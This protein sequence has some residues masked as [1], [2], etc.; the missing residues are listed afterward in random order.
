[1]AAAPEM[2]TRRSIGAGLVGLALAGAVLG[3]RSTNDA[4]LAS[5][6]GWD[7]SRAEVVTWRATDPAF[8]QDHALEASGLAAAGGKLYVAS[9]KYASLLVVDAATD[10][11]ARVVRIAVPANSELEGISATQRE[12]LLCDEAH[13]AV[14]SVNSDA[15]SAAAA[16]D[17]AS[18]ERRLPVRALKLRGVA[19]RGGKIG[20]EGIE[21]D[22]RTDD[23]MLLLERSQVHGGGCV[24]MVFRLRRLED[25]LVLRGRPI[26]VE[27]ADCAWRLTGLAWWGGQLIALRT[28][29]PGERYEVVSINVLTGAA[30]VVL[31]LTE[32]LRSLVLEGW[33]NNVEGIAVA[34]DGALW[35]VADNAVTGVINERVPPPTDQLTLL[36]RVPVAAE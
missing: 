5:L 3:C 36:V 12:L 15:V 2:N 26:E 13:A 18:G 20:F 21:V 24:S 10:T 4:G 1:M 23:V 19:V 28:Q 14:Y 35:L 16:D 29:F 7:L 30:T 11:E 27:L 9:E 25:S 17:E 31:D 32:L 8:N 6:P 34:D 33:G 22:P